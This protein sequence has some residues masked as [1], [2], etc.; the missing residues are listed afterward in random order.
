MKPKARRLPVH[1]RAEV[2]KMLG[3]YTTLRIVDFLSAAG[4]RFTELQR[5]LG[6]T[7]SVTLSNRLKRMT[8]A[9]LVNRSEAAVNG[10]SVTYSLSGMGSALLPVIRE[11]RSF[12]GRYFPDG[13]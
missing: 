13:G 9:G 11:I 5:A 7:N 12:A 4:M 2:L 3:D 10:Q 8:E 1:C 6:D